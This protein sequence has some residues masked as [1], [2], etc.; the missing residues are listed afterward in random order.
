[1]IMAIAISVQKYLKDMHIP[2]DVVPHART[3]SSLQTSLAA[4]VPPHRIAKAVLLEDDRGLLMAV[5]PADRHIHL[6][7]L[8]DELGRQVNLADERKVMNIFPDCDLG[9]IPPVGPAY[10]L[11]TILDDELMEQPEVFLEAGSHEELIQLSRHHF[12]QL[13]RD[14]PRVRFART[15]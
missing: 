7:V 13:F 2:Y 5:L 11:D 10:G 12:Q 15:H 3:L 8:R 14:A 9:A 1:M 6:A 4:H